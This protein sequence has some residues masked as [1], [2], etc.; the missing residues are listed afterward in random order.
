M[1]LVSHYDDDLAFS[2]KRRMPIVTFAHRDIK[3]DVIVRACEE[4]GVVVR[5]GFFLSEKCFEVWAENWRRKGGGDDVA[6]KLERE[7]AVRVSMAHY[8]TEE[9][10]GKLVEVLERIKGWW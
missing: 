5:A 10:V 3:A 4:S 8:N 6:E 9:E 7:G 1:V 2:E